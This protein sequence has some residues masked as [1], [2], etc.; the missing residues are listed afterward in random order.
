MILSTDL[1]L[2]SP[3]A[4]L[5]N[6]KH[7]VARLLVGLRR[8]TGTR[9]SFLARF[10]GERRTIRQ[11][12]LTGSPQ[13]PFRRVLIKRCAGLEDSSRN[14]SLWMTL[15][16]L[17]IVN[18]EISRVIDCLAREVE[19]EGEASMAALKPSPEVGPEVVEAYEES[20]DALLRTV[21]GII[22]L[23]TK[24]RY[25]HPWFGPMDAFAWF[26]MAG[27]HLAIHRLQIERILAGTAIDSLSPAR[28]S[29]KSA[30]LV[31][32]IAIMAAMVFLPGCTTMQTPTTSKNPA[33]NI[34]WPAAYEPSKAAFYI[35][36]EINI[37]A[38]PEVVWEILVQAEQWPDW[39]VGATD[40]KIRDSEDGVLRAD[41]VMN[42]R[43]M[44]M[45]FESEVKEFEPPYR[46]A[47]ESRKAVI[48]GYHAWILI[49][50]KDGT[51]VVTD[52]S[53]H[54]FLGVMQ[55][56]FLP[57]RLRRLHDIFL[58]EL[59]IKAEAEMERRASK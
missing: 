22:D 9:E 50:T 56:L 31:A 55:R 39:Y 58:Q 6:I 8:R 21:A 13:Q 5:P 35:S 15:D 42:W 2:A 28:Q 26:G 4:G 40:V 23:K 45:T 19:P 52:E 51:R 57:N 20:C 48:Q 33:E 10:E 44:D 37:A 14:W 24:L 29:S 49:R 54:G 53:F 43:T 12:V 38:P 41:S 34:R 59:K 16:H 11:L 25:A 3:G 30:T 36:N 32:A 27:G 1:N 18:L 47:W 17:R 7:L 46:L